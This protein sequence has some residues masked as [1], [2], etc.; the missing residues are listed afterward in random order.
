MT[1]NEIKHEIKVNIKNDLKL[2]LIWYWGLISIILIFGLK[3]FRSKHLILSPEINFLQG[4]LPNLFAATAFCAIF[5]IYYKLIFR[6]D[7]SFNKK[8][9]FST[10]LTFLGLVIW[11][12]IQYFMGSRID[13]YDILMTTIGCILTAAFIK[14]VFMIKSPL[15]NLQGR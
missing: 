3:Y 12:I 6:I 2:R 9:I 14:L 4:T 13:F 7:S 8:L 10:L 1:F 11:E 15:V 5:F